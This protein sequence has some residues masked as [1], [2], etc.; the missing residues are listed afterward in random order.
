MC[1]KLWSGWCAVNGGA[2][3][4]FDLFGGPEI[5]IKEILGP[6]I[7]IKS[8]WALKVKKMGPSFR[9]GAHKILTLGPKTKKWLSFFFLFRLGAHN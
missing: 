9:L 1:I 4:F 8:I 2:Q 3:G 5:M 6:K 7:T